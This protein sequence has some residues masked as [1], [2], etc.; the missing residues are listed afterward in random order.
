ML[1]HR[2]RINDLES[3]TSV[4]MYQYF[5]VECIVR[6]KGRGSNQE[7]LGGSVCVVMVILNEKRETVEEYLPLYIKYNKGFKKRVEIQ[8]TM[9]IV[10]KKK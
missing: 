7:T 6:L 4:S 9:D 5:G 10:I 1:F 3:L 8:T 2:F